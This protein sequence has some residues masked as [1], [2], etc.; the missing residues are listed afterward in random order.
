[1]FMP[2]LISRPSPLLYD[3]ADW[4]PILADKSDMATVPA[5]SVVMPAYN[6]RRYIRESVQSVLQQTFTDFEFI[7][8]DDGSTDGTGDML[9]EYAAKDARIRLVSRPNTGYAVA[10]NEALGMARAPFLARMGESVALPLH[11]EGDP[12]VSLPSDQ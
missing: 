6:V 1:M 8:I 10:L 4:P 12:F 7:I 2:A 11:L 9:H 3:R 5:I